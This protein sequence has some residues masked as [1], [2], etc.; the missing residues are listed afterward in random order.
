MPT[1][2]LPPALKKWL[3]AIKKT[4]EELGMPRPV[5]L[6]KNTKFY[7][8]ARKH[9]DFMNSVFENVEWKPSP[10]LTLSQK[11]KLKKMKKTKSKK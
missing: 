3:S 10:K 9:Y 8:V 5:P 4:E 6:K 11:A 1:K 7:K 2:K